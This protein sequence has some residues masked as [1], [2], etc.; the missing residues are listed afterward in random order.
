MKPDFALRGI[1]SIQHYS[2][3]PT[4]DLAAGFGQPEE[5]LSDDQ[6]L[7]MSTVAT[8][9]KFFNLAVDW[10]EV[11]VVRSR[12]CSR[13][14]KEALQEAKDGHDREL[15]GME[16][17]TWDKTNNMVSHMREEPY[18]EELRKSEL[19][20]RK[21]DLTERFSEWSSQDRDLFWGLHPTKHPWAAIYVGQEPQRQR[22]C[23][24]G[25][26]SSVVSHCSWLH[27]GNHYLRLG[28]FKYEEVRRNPWVGILRNIATT[29]ELEQV[30]EEAQQ[31]ALVPTSLVH[32]R[33]GVYTEDTAGTS[34][35]TSKV[36]YRSE[37]S[38]PPLA[39]WTRRFELATALSMTKQRTDS[40][41]YQIMNY[42]LGG[43]ILTHRDSDNANLDDDSFSESWAQGGPRLA[44]I[45][46]WL[47]TPSHGGRTVF[48]G[49]GG[50]LQIS[51]KF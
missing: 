15:M 24:G 41:N 7:H 1:F 38:L 20:Q 3:I 25:V 19:F 5:K 29:S 43:A 49:A 51:E 14:L 36:T 27:R 33:G 12:N 31:A 18:D 39:A 16:L 17:G 22:L 32:F 26:V 6:V 46:V 30:M 2:G 8:S 4:Q 40:E 44:T 13:R 10:L 11:A 48:T 45:M 23:Q 37:A 9:E 35:R 47:K 28:P 34:R 21:R 42:G 50:I